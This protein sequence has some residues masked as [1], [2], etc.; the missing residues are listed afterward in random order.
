MPPSVSLCLGENPW[1]LYIRLVPGL[2]LI[3]ILAALAAAQDSPVFVVERVLDGDTLVLSNSERVRLLGIDAPE[4]GMVLSDEARDRLRELT[5]GREVKLRTCSEKDQYDRLL[6]VVLAGDLNVNLTLLEE[7]LA[8]PMLIPPCGKMVTPEVLRAA[9]KA[10][11]AGTG[12]YALRGYEVVPH[13]R[14]AE[15]IGK[16]AVVRGKVLSLHKGEKAWHLNFGSDWKTDFTAVLF[17]HG[18]LRFEDLGVDP[19]AL[20]GTEVLVIGNV[21]SYNG[22]EIIL[23]GPEQI[24]PVE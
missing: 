20:V 21:K 8:V 13:E 22:P 18:R 4:R 2:C 5:K 12:I 3:L 9:E 1:K 19:E 6:S 17:R 15:H 23:R 10:I 24:I 11:S 16:Q 14:A 7:G